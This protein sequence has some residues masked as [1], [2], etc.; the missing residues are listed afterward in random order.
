M[1]RWFWVTC[2]FMLVC[3]G[4]VLPRT[5]FGQEAVSQAVD[6]KED[7]KKAEEP[8]T[9]YV[10]FSDLNGSFEKPETRI[11]IPFEEYRKLVESLRSGQTPPLAP[12]A[13][14][15]QA[16]YDV[17]V[18]GE[19]ARITAKLKV[20][21]LR[22]GWA[23]VPIRFGAATIGSMK[24]A[25]GVLLRGTAEGQSQLLFPD[26]GNY[27]VELQLAAR[28][29]Q[30]PESR[31]VSFD[32]PPV[33]LTTVQVTVPGKGQQITITPA[34]AALPPPATEGDQT[35]AS[36]Q[37]G[38]V[39]KVSIRW[40]PAE[41]QTPAMNLLAS[42]NNRT[43]VTIAD[44]LIHTE[45]TLAYDILRGELSETQIVLPKSSRLLD[46]FADQGASNWTTE[47]E[48][49][50]QIVTLKLSAPVKQK[51]QVTVRA[52]TPLRESEFSVAGISTEKVA[53]GI[54]AL[55]AV[56]ESG[57]VA[58]RHNADLSVNVLDQQGLVRI[59][60]SEADAKL[61]GPN[62]LL[63]KFYSPQ[64]LLRLAAQPVAPRL[65]VDHQIDLKFQDDELRFFNTLNYQ[66]ERAGV[67]ELTL[68]LPEGVIIDQVNSPVMKEFNIDSAQR[69]LTVALRE[70]TKGQV[71]LTIQGH[72]NLADGNQE[73]FRLPIL[74]PLQVEREQG[75][76][77][78]FSRDSLEVQ[79]VQ[80]KVESAQPLP[81][82]SDSTQGDLQ[83]SSRWTF[84]RR[85]VVIPVRLIRKPTRLR[86][87]QGTAFQIN[88]EQAQVTS[89]LTYLIEY[90]PVDE[91]RIDVPESISSR[92]QIEVPA[93]ETDSAPIK[94]KDPAP[95]ENGRVVWTIQTSRKVSKKQTFLL[96]YD[97]LP[98]TDAEKLQ[99]EAKPAANAT[100]AAGG[101]D[102]EFTLVRPLGIRGPD[103]KGEVPLAEYRG[104]I[105][106]RKEQ[107]LSIRA[108]STGTGI[109]QIDV[110]E[111]KLLPETATLAFRY[112]RDDK[113][114]PI[115]LKV[116]ASHFDVQ[117]VVAT[118][119]SRGLVEIVASEDQSV[120]CRCRYRVKS[121]ERQRLLIFL[122]KDL[123][124]LGAFLNDREVKLEKAEVPV[125][126]HLNPALVPFWLNVARPESSET[127]FLLTLQF[128]WN[129]KSGT[130]AYLLEENLLSLPLPVLGADGQGVVQELKVVVWMPEDHALI[131]DPDPFLLQKRRRPWSFVLGTPADHNTSG[132]S[133]WVS[134]GV[135]SSSGFAEL[136]TEGRQPYIFSTLGE[137]DEITARV[138]NKNWMTLLISGS[139]VLIGWILLGTSWENKLGI[140]LLGFFAA[141]MYGLFDSHGLSQGIHAAR[142]GLGVMF[143]MWL[144]H[145]FFSMIR[146]RPAPRTRDYVTTDVPYA[147][148]PPPGVFE[149]LQ[150]GS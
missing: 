14:L 86:A 73:D 82:F 13:V 87:Q 135:T 140:L 74:E 98:A 46:V 123:E 137:A 80:G 125:P 104:E 34:G 47:V 17:R 25:D 108:S 68:Q 119:I 42:V 69:K 129:L 121:A 8:K 32:C 97:L 117:D 134:E 52:E 23:E 6:G 115:G 29:H 12:A 59:E 43:L 84:T 22:D 132:L 38:A 89:T 120:T 30:S 130:N 1:P 4:T 31:D 36:A 5:V 35:R 100:T 58:I 28:V 77:Q 128:L 53:A 49:E 15:T 148:I 112:F 145:G 102:Y 79:A 109:E 105:A 147:V 90:A 18:E 66:I 9:I 62:A 106:V 16:D 96:T 113:D 150:P 64:I 111:L 19:S 143:A 40:K 118:A 94:Q 138:W 133:G 93:G 103:G 37:I 78:I 24:S 142:A 2:L 92:L 10:P 27:D 11:V 21:V 63:F 20:Q 122:P 51:L 127:P 75:T 88:P 7:Q 91:F 50:N 44:G 71:I 83:L 149:H 3:S 146:P 48:G 101:K 144:L 39:N 116:T 141:A 139:L 124:V 114:N 110:R 33:A 95:V 131:G 72:L 55:D 57:Q 41:S 85:P 70:R 56:R 60:N 54:H 126:K 99:A 45:A 136:P 81:I 76:V 107:T 65:I 26:K 67:F 61:A